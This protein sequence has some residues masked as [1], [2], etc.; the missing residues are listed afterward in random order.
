MGDAA[1]V[2]DVPAVGD[3]VTCARAIGGAVAVGVTYEKYASHH[4]QHIC[5][6]HN[7]S[8]NNDANPASLTREAKQ[9]GNGT[10]LASW[11]A[12]ASR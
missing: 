2:G 3:K 8:C 5:P 1:A 10:C 6:L 11:G 4:R 12:E 7:V 9:A